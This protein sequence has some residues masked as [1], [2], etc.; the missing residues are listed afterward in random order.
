MSGQKVGIIW[1]GTMGN[2]IAQV[3]VVAGLSVR[4]M[5]M[6]DRYLARGS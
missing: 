4:S 1:A 5:G 6:L 2:G 3:C